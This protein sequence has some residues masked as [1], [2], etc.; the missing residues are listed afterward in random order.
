MKIRIVILF[1]VFALFGCDDTQSQIR[2]DKQS[3]YERILVID[4]NDRRYLRFGKPNSANESVISLSDPRAVPAEYIRIAALGAML[5]PNPNRALMIGLGGGTYTTLL[6]RHFPNLHIDA[7]EIDPVV[8]EVAKT[9]FGVREDER[10]KIHVADGAIFVRE[11]QSIYDLVFIDAYSGEG[12]PQALSGPSF[13]DA[14][15]AKTSAEGVV[16]LNLF[17]QYGTEQS[18]IQVFRTRFPHTA[19]VRSSDDLNLVLFGKTSDMPARADLI[20]ATRRFSAA[21]DLSFDL[22]KIAKKLVM[23]CNGLGLAYVD[24]RIRPIPS[25][26]LSSTA[27]PTAIFPSAPRPRF[28]GFFFPP[29]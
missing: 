8:V 17:N 15:K 13:F 2:F 23:K 25:S 14:V 20:A 28:P 11:T 24:K 22:E 27:I 16:V 7:V 29:M 19:C 9:F 26:S 12:I 4:K 6:R 18:L 5:T 1:V 3:E 10:F 21:A